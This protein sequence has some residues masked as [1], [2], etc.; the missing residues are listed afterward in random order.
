MVE[1]PTVNQRPPYR[2]QKNDK[3]ICWSGINIEQ[4]ILNITFFT[5]LSMIRLWISM[6]YLQANFRSDRCPHWVLWPTT[7]R[8]PRS[9][10]GDGGHSQGLGSH[11]S[12]INVVLTYSHKASWSSPAKEVNIYINRRIMENHGTPVR[13]WFAKKKNLRNID[14]LRIGSGPARSWPGGR[15]WHGTPRSARIQIWCL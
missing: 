13:C 11:V 10:P 5:E 12:C 6:N 3:R 8:V 4:S 14:A 15:A 9:D 2:D 1:T 7:G